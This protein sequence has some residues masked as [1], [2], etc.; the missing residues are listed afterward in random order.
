MFTYESKLISDVFAIVFS[1]TKPTTRKIKSSLFIT[2]SLL[3]SYDTVLLHSKVVKNCEVLWGG[4]VR[5][6]QKD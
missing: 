5:N 6:S 4:K 2:P 1:L 3:I